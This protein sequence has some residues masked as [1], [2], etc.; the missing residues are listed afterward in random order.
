MLP[1]V[2]DRERVYLQAES[3]E[4]C[5]RALVAAARLGVA[6]GPAGCSVPLRPGTDRC[7][8]L[9]TGSRLGPTLCD[10]C[11][12]EVVSV[13]DWLTHLRAV[14]ALEHAT[15]ANQRVG[16]AY[17]RFAVR[18]NTIEFFRWTD[19]A[20]A[21]FA[22][23]VE[24]SRMTPLDPVVAARLAHELVTS[25]ARH[26][27]LDELCGAHVAREIFPSPARRHPPGHRWWVLWVTRFY[28]TDTPVIAHLAA[29]RSAVWMDGA[30]VTAVPEPIV[31]AD[32]PVST[33]PI[34]SG[35]VLGVTDSPRVDATVR[36]ALELARAGA[37]PPAQAIELASCFV[38][39]TD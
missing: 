30:V 3:P 21:P 16:A 23:A 5:A 10:H 20:L 25:G 27:G 38:R 14:V 26:V 29:A 24:A 19:L 12:G 33:C 11:A 35:T 4:W 34:G 13:A 7:V 39:R 8:H 36:F 22:A 6:S 2:R 37:A 15:A 18:R 1:T 31:P 32:W 17:D 28:A 9:P